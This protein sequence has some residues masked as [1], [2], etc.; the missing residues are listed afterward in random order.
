M[1][2]RSTLRI[3][4]ALKANQAIFPSMQ[5]AFLSTKSQGKVKWFDTKKGF[6]FITP[7][8]GGEDIFVHQSQIK[9]DGFR[10]LTGK[11]PSVLV[12]K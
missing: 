10:S 12:H 6:G 4:S 2:A 5:Y 11:L 9:T 1:L 3:A 7:T 8:T